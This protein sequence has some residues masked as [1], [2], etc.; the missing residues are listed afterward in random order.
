[1]DVCFLC[2]RVRFLLLP[3][4]LVGPGC[5]LFRE[6][7][8]VRPKLGFTIDGGLGLSAGVDV[9]AAG[10]AASLCVRRKTSDEGGF[11]GDG[12]DNTAG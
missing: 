11:L 12:C 5:S 4:P 6:E 8:L 7:A 1:M 3:P 9:G 10:D 2:L